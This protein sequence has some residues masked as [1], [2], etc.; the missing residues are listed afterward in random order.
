MWSQGGDVSRPTALLQKYA[1]KQSKAAARAPLQQAGIAPGLVSIAL[2]RPLPDHQ[3]R[4]FARWPRRDTM[5]AEPEHYRRLLWRLFAGLRKG[6]AF[7][8]AAP[9]GR[10]RSVRFGCAPLQRAPD[11]AG[12]HVNQL[13]Q[14][15]QHEEN[16]P[17]GDCRVDRRADRSIALAE[18]VPDPRH[19][20]RHYESAKDRGQKSR[21][22]AGKPI[23]FAPL[24]RCRLWVGRPSS[25]R[26]A[27]C[28]MTALVGVGPVAA[29]WLSIRET[30]TAMA[31]RR[32]RI[33]RYFPCRSWPS[34][35]VQNDFCEERYDHNQRGNQPQRGRIDG[36]EAEK[37]ARYLA[38][39]YAKAALPVPQLRRGPRSDGRETIICS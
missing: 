30:Q 16:C 4:W 11:R 20:P 19:Q 12:G 2:N 37:S 28:R 3:R 13:R 38:P 1:V 10:P 26:L 5:P 34:D 7:M 29:C 21:A 39:P 14:N 6:R 36:G 18:A 25:A 17:A 35:P 8:P 31:A 15:Q 33:S 24:R 22:L 27:R 32:R 23:H 9:L